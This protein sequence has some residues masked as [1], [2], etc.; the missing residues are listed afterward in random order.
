MKTTRYFWLLGLLLSLMSC[1]PAFDLGSLTPT[2][3]LKLDLPTLEPE[4]SQQGFRFTPVSELNEEELAEGA[5]VV[6]VQPVLQ[7]QRFFDAQTLF[8]KEVHQIWSRQ[9][10]PTYGWAVCHLRGANE[11]NQGVGF[12]CVSITSMGLLNLLGFPVASYLNQVE[13]EVEIFDRHNQ[14]IRRY[15]GRGESNTLVGLYYG[16]R[17]GRARFV[18]VMQQALAEIRSQVAE[19]Q[20]FLR[21]RLLNASQD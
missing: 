18:E 12:S 7:D 3:S 4:F 8:R 10:T 13:V 9:A 21:A 2:T 14:L 20:D 15:Y 1:R 16:Q 19:D 5:Y 11:V 17:S 6:P